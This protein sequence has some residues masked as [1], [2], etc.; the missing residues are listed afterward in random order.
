MRVLPLDTPEPFAA[1]LGVM[2][3]PGEDEKSRRKARAYA[4]QYLSAASS[5]KQF[6]IS[7]DAA[8]WIAQHAGQTIDRLENRWRKAQAMGELTKVYLGLI[9]SAPERASWNSAKT[10]VSNDAR[11]EEVRASDTFDVMVW[12][13]PTFGI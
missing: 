1:T 6:S 8:Q 10:I 7:T 3:Y 11:E 12:T 2:L 13:A 9:H 4:A 5:Q